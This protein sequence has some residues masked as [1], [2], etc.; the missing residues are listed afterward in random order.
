MIRKGA[1]IAW[2]PSADTTKYVHN[3]LATSGKSSGPDDPMAAAL[4]V[5]TVEQQGLDRFLGGTLAFASPAE[6][7][8]Y[9]QVLHAGIEELGVLLRKDGLL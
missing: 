6:R 5:L 8:A 4:A 2:N 7:L 9:R 1:F 3:S